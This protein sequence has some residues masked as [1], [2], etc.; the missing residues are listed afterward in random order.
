M[1]KESYCVFKKKKIKL[2]LKFQFSIL[3]FILFIKLANAMAD[4][5]FR[6]QLM[7]NNTYFKWNYLSSK[8]FTQIGKM[9]MERLLAIAL[10]QS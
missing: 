9:I 3:D 4:C 8:M 6:V 7:L 1:F 5:S 10:W 2:S